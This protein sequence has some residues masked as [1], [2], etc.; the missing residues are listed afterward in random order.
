MSHTLPTL[1]YAYDALQPS[2][3]QETMELHHSKHHQTY[4]DNL[5]RLIAGTEYESMSLEEIVQ[6][7]PAGGIFNNAGQHWNHSQF[8]QMLAPVGTGAEPTGAFVDAINK[9]FGS[10]EA[11]K[12]QF[13]VTGATT[14]GSGWVWLAQE[15]DGCLSLMS[16][17]NADSPLRHGKNALLGV[18]VWEHAYYVD[19]RNRR[20]E[21]LSQIWNIVNWNNVMERFNG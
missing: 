4:V 19:Y 7:A 8:W 1:P 16:A 12:E 9:A 18:D 14:F 20:P 13:A 10:F 11:F 5:N 17:S 21:Y 3:G 2:I 6:K 15:A